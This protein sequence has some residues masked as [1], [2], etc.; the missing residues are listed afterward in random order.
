MISRSN[1]NAPEK[2]RAIY[3]FLKRSFGPQYWWPAK[4]P[5]EVTVGAILTQN[6]AWTN[7]EK[8]IA[9]LRS[10]GQLSL[11]ALS[12]LP[13]KRLA[14]LIR[15]AGYF[16]VKAVRL[17]AWT[18]YLRAKGCKTDLKPLRG[19]PTE[20]LRHEMLEVKGIGPETADSILL[21]ALDRPVFVVDAYTKRVLSRHGLLDERA[22][23]G[24]TQDLFIRSLKPSVGLFNEYHALLVALG[25]DYCRPRPKCAE[26]PLNCLFPSKKAMLRVLL[27]R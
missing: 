5:F 7:V 14:R 9:S 25:K 19:V 27:G 8:A 16:N 3:G 13:R 2:L 15:P 23:Y 26:C 11:S 12:G 6:T 10:A 4:T 22:S 1:L 21:Y 17:Q 18:R 20:K 24:E